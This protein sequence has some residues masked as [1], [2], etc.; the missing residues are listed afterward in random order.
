MFNYFITF[1]FKPRNEDVLFTF[2][3]LPRVKYFSLMSEIKHD[4]NTLSF[5]IKFTA[6]GNKHNVCRFKFILLY[7]VI[8][9]IL[10]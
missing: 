10:Q 8:L 9:R 4:F 7:D 3:P 6:K 2:L 5:C 1:Y